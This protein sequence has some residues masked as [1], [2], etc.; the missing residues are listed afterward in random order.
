MHTWLFLSLRPQTIFFKIT[1]MIIFILYSITFLFCII[2]ENTWIFLNIFYFVNIVLFFQISLF[3]DSLCG[4]V[5]I[6]SASHIILICCS[7]IN[8][9][10]WLNIVSL[11]YY[12]VFESKL[13]SNL[14]FNIVYLKKLYV[15]DLFAVVAWSKRMIQF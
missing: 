11:L 6:V 15:F 3:I 13:F 14:F 4:C 1:F 12:L 10:T 5:H 2:R 7:I 8:E 9:Y